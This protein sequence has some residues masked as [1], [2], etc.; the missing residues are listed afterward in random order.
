[1]NPIGRGTVPFY[2]EAV[3]IVPN[4]AT[5]FSPTLALNVQVAGVVTV[6]MVGT[7]TNIGLYCGQGTHKLAV[8]RVYST[9]TTAT[10]ITALRA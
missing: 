3:A 4:D 6:D 5:T 9:G 8:T 1:M 10:G 7:G 2:T